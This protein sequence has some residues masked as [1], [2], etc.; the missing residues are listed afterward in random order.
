MN[1]NLVFPFLDP[2]TFFLQLFSSFPIIL[3]NLLIYSTIWRYKEEFKLPRLLLISSLIALGVS[4]AFF[5]IPGVEARNIST[6]E[7]LILNLYFIWLSLLISLPTQFIPAL[8]LLIFGYFNKDRYKF[9]LLLAGT[10]LLAYHLISFFT[11]TLMRLTYPS[12]YLENIL[13]FLFLRY[14]IF[15][16]ILAAYTFLIIHGVLNKQ[17]LFRN[18]AIIMSGTFIFIFFFSSYFVQLIVMYFRGN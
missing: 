16:I 11:S 5:F 2:E 4:L 14:M 10:L 1:I 8:S 12:S 3:Y 7:M 9:Y 18:T 17:P 15:G 6:E 13:L